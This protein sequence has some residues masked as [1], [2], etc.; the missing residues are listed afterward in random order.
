MAKKS[1]NPCLENI[2]AAAKGEISEAEA[3]R[4][5]RDLGQRARAR[6]AE[7]AMPLEAAAAEVAEEL[8]AQEAMKAALQQRAAL[9]NVRARRR[10][11]DS[12]QR[13]G[14]TFGEGVIDYM[15]EVYNAAL[16]HTNRWKMKLASDAEEAGVLREFRKG[17]P[18]LS[19]DWFTEMWQLS[20]GLPFKT[21][22][23]AAQVFAKSM[24]EMSEQYMSLVNKH[25]ANVQAAP[26][27][28]G[29]QTHSPD[30]LRRAGNAA[31]RA[32]GKEN[33]ALS[34]EVWR[35][36]VGTLKIDW[37]R[38]LPAGTKEEQERFLKG[39]HESSYSGIHGEATEIV[40]PNARLGMGSFA[41]KVSSQRLL[42]FLDA[43]SQFDYNQRWGKQDFNTM[44]LSMADNFGRNV[45]MLEYLGPN[46]QNNFN[47]GVRHL[48]EAAKG[49]DNAQ[50]QEQSLQRRNIQG[51]Y[52]LISGKTRGSTR[53]WLS[54]L[55]D[56]IKRTA[57][58]AKGGGIAFSMAGDRGFIDT[59]MVLHNAT[60]LQRI[61]TQIGRIAARGAEGKKLLRSIGFYSHAML[62]HTEERWTNDVRGGKKTRTLL[63]W[64]F[65]LQ[66]V[67]RLT[68][69]HNKAAFSW[70]ME[71][72]GQN[73]HLKFDELPAIEQL[74]LRNH[75]VSPEE[76]EAMR[77]TAFK[78][79][80]DDVEYTVLVPD[81]M[82][83]LPDEAVSALLRAEGVDAPTHTQ[84]SR[85][86]DLLESKLSALY[87]DKVQE[88]V[89]TPGL[90]E[91]LLM[92]GDAAQR[93]P[94]AR[95]LRELFFIFKGFGLTVAMRNLRKYQQLYAAK[96]YRALGMQVAL[97][98]AKTTALGYLGWAAREAF[99]GKTPPSPFDSNGEVDGAAFTNILLESMKRGG[100]L[101]IYGDYMLSEYD[102]AHRSFLSSAAGPAL[103]ELDPL[104]ALGTTVRK[105]A[106]GEE[107][108]EKFGY[109]A[110]RFVENNTPFVNLFYTKFM[111]DQFI[112][113][114]LKEGLSP[115]V[116][117]REERRM[118]DQR[119]QEFWIE[120]ITDY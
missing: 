32:Y 116:L 17:G 50:A 52:D 105:A 26:G 41:E 77:S 22:N 69:L 108:P 6:A 42:W 36:H 56:L 3:G 98:V 74:E 88:M 96:Q 10:F 78:F 51:A 117:R 109:D 111:L 47:L 30:L 86:R 61:N 9:M 14:K 114:N 72:H 43:E 2:L 35:E 82:Q 110:L 11:V 62:G 27:W 73:A 21:Q 81:R 63:D 70:Q 58:G 29:P 65:R 37:E 44:L 120:P 76:W 55:V 115:G 15:N 39:F 5:L 100:G 79:N 103:S 25:G 54:N 13:R 16:V 8:K 60:A 31:G 91:K 102:K 85:R 4:I 53:P 83:D 71:I 84:R 101:G 18:E 97:L 118:R 75:D 1:S 119:H 57:L 34:Y 12:A 90:R 46:A 28:T 80:P 40:D 66:G 99:K 59:E 112:L 94:L 24:H 106:T 89:P 38:T 107:I 19:R 113:W 20:N 67:D 93:G 23:N 45:A 92:T 87:A 104:M 68:D 48:Q 95:E 49:L 7:N 33:Q 64:M